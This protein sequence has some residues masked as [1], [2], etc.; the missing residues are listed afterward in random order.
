[1]PWAFDAEGQQD[2]VLALSSTTT[3][4]PDW[5]RPDAVAIQPLDNATV[6]SPR[7]RFRAL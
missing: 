2:I 4:A 6:E 5:R 3:T 1:M 7:F